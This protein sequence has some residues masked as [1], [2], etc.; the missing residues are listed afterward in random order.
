MAEFPRHSAQRQLTTQQPEVLRRDAQDRAQIT[1][2]ALS[3]VTDMA[4]KLDN[5]FI[6]SQLNA[7]KAEKGVFLAKAKNDALLDPNSN[8]MDKHLKVISDYKKNGLKDISPRAR[9]QAQLEFDTDIALAEIQIQGI[10]QKKVIDE[11]VKN[12]AVS[13]ETKLDA[14]LSTTNPAEFS[15]QI[16]QAVAQ[17]ND[18]VLTGIISPDEGKRLKEKYKED[19]RLGIIDRD[20]YSDPLRF[21]SNINKGVYQF[22][23]EKE[24][25]TKL[26]IA[27]DSIKAAENLDKWHERQIHT[28]N[29]YDLSNQ[30]LQRT[31]SPEG[32]KQVYREGKIDFE[33]AA[34]FEEVLTTGNYAIPDETKL[35]KPDFLLRL[36]D[37]VLDDKTASLDVMKQAARAFG[38]KDIGANQYAYFV[39]EANKKFARMQKGEKGWGDELLKG[40][41]ESIKNFAKFTSPTGHA[42]TAANLLSRF[43]D[44]LQNGT[45]PEIASDEV[46]R[47]ERINKY[48]WIKNLPKEGER[49]MFP[50]GVVRRV[51]PDGRIEDAK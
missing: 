41:V 7:V 36:L 19:L 11:S 20:L 2:K 32:V 35:G 27:D 37:D 42:L 45:S 34:I 39:N 13:L 50:D 8:N 49:R 6:T 31:L 22:K 5:A 1:T 4:V 30:L 3:D 24:K 9:Q 25:A 21:K 10:F 46:I 44:R 28:T 17:I 48:S 33:T 23:N 12:L 29:A 16:T 51:Y 26:G 47:Q 14:A 18:N 40:A 15:K 38:R 43:I